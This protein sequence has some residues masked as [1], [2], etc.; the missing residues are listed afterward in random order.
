MKSLQRAKI[1]EIGAALLKSGY[2]SLDEQAKVLGLARS[3]TWT[4]L[5]S[6]H[7][8]SG[9]SATIINRMLASQRLPSLVRAKVVH[10]VEEKVAGVYGDNAPQLR[11]FKT[12]MNEALALDE[13]KLVASGDRRN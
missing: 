2:C 8:H 9:L 11:R 6:T 5:K 3:T 4:I 1:Q 7:K 12:Q 13:G 10:Y